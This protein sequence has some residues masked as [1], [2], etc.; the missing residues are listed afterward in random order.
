MG[1]I[2]NFLL[3]LL[4]LLPLPVFSDRFIDDDYEFYRNMGSGGGGDLLGFIVFI[5]LHL[6]A[7]AFLFHSYAMW[8]NRRK[9]NEK[10]KKKDNIVDWLFTA[11]CYLIV[12]IFISFPIALIIKWSIDVR[13]MREYWPFVYIASFVLLAYFRRT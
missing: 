5:F 13:A 3:W 8:K 12:A 2:K 9:N 7:Y 4:F 11:I 1:F 6:A 10:P